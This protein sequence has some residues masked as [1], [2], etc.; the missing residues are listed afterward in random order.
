MPIKN[1][2]G[3]NSTTE[4]EFGQPGTIKPSARPATATP[5]AN[6]A[7]SRGLAL[8][9]ISPPQPRGAPPKPPSGGALSMLSQQLAQPTTP[10]ATPSGGGGY[11]AAPPP[12]P[13]APTMP[14]PG[15]NMSP[16]Q[17]TVDPALTKGVDVNLPSMFDFG[18]PEHA[19]PALGKGSPAF[20]GLMSFFKR[21]PA[22]Y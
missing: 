3:A 6:G 4:R 5:G 15:L 10:R 18:G 11:P 13:S 14:P 1:L 21:R 12:S 16:A 22:A 20:E 2:W 9:R 19:N 8:S 17:A 7:V